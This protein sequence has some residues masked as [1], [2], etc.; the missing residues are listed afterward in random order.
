VSFLVFPAAGADAWVFCSPASAAKPE[1]AKKQTVKK[2]LKKTQAI[3]L[4]GHL[5][6]STVALYVPHRPRI[7]MI[8]HGFRKSKGVPK[9]A[10]KQLPIGL[11]VNYT[12]KT[13]KITSCDVSRVGFIIIP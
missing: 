4:I 7:H 11:P 3:L 8:T 12:V 5:Q 9:Q 6:A 2:T 13:G 1:T 10:G